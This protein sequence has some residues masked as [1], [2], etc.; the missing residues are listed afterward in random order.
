MN[1]VCVV[2]H[3]FMDCPLLCLS[4]QEGSVKILWGVFLVILEFKL[5]TL[6]LLGRRSTT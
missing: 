2:A 6:H 4:A 5:G 3:F 1:A